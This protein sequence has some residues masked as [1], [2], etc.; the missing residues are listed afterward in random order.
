GA[1][2]DLAERDVLRDAAAHADR[3]PALQLLLRVV[4]LLLGGQLLGEAER[5]A[6]R[7]DRHLVERVAVRQQGGDQ[8][9]PALQVRRGLLT[10]GRS[11]AGSS[12]SGRLVAAIRMTPSL[13]SNPSISTRSWFRVCSRSS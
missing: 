4:V 5:H 2:R 1:G 13:D 3:D 7:D 11:S 10:L 8:R 12:T 9:V 6:S